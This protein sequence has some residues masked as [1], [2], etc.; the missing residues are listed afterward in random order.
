MPVTDPIADMLTRIRNAVSARHDSVL[1]PASTLKEA[2][3]HILKREGFI[4]DFELVKEEPQNKIRIH[5]RYVETEREKEAA[6]HGLKRV[7]KPG[8]RVHVQK[9]EIPR[10]YGG[11]GISILSTSQG[12]MTGQEA[13]QRGV[14]GELLCY[15]W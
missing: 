8:L 14:G 9:G 12:V 5:L 1:I 15:V 3:C 7:S 10:I 6:I 13:W 4:K 2:I 11:P